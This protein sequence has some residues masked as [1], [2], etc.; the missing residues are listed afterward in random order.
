MI[1]EIYL[2][3]PDLNDTSGD[4]PQFN[5]TLKRNVGLELS[6]KNGCTHH[7]TIDVDEFYTAFNIVEGDKMYLKPEERVKIW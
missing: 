3:E 5:E 2:F 4:N 6:K 1:D 7:M